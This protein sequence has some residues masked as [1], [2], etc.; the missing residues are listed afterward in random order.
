MKHRV[1]RMTSILT[2]VTAVT[3]LAAVPLV[4]Q[5]PGADPANYTPPRTPWG[6]PDLQS[7]WDTRTYTPLERPAEFGTRE[8]MAEEEAAER[9]RLDYDGL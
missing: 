4:G 2:V 5:A 7:M 9:E 3:W 8:F 1:L 6:D